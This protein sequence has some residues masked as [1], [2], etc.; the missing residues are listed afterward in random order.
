MSRKLNPIYAG[1]NTL[2]LVNLRIKTLVKY[3]D[4][5]HICM[6]EVNL[7][8]QEISIPLLKFTFRLS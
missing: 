3:R 8:G 6:R 7:L 5:E 1:E 4:S 2:K